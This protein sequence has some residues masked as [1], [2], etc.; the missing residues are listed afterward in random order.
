MARYVAVPMAADGSDRT[1][2][3]AREATV[4]GDYVSVANFM[5]YAFARRS[6]LPGQYNL[7]WVQAIGRWIYLQVLYRT[8]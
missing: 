6:T 2:A 3:A 7:Y 1:D 4:S 8:V 5:R